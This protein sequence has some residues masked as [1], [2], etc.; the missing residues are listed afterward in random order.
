MSLQFLGIQLTRTSHSCDFLYMSNFNTE[1]LGWFFLLILTI[2][3]IHTA[4]R[5][6]NKGW[7]C[8][9]LH[10]TEE[11]GGCIWPMCHPSG[12]EG[13]NKNMS[14]K[15]IVRKGFSIL[16]DGICMFLGI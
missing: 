2:F 1:M 5:C 13:W 10:E 11:A 16:F 12:R 14:F 8:V 7:N 15:D 6:L 9:L 4:N 3:E